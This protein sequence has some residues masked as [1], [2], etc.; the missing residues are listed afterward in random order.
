MR[1]RRNNLITRWGGFTLIELLV[2]VAILSLLVSILLPSLTKAKELAR[3]A[4]CYANLRSLNIAFLLYLEDNHRKFFPYQKNCTDGTL[5][6]WGFEPDGSGP[7]GQRQIDPRRARLAPYFP[8]T[9]KVQACPSIPMDAGYWKG[10]FDL[11]GYGYG[12]NYYLLSE[13]NP[14]VSF[15]DIARPSDTIVWGD[16]VQI[17]TWQAPASPSNPML[18]EWYWLVNQRGTGA[19]F[20]FRHLKTCTAVMADGSIW[21]L[22]PYWLDERCDGLVGRPEE[23][24][25][26]PA[27]GETA[28][29]SFLLRLGAK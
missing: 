14:G 1:K 28:T 12:I 24:P 13:H 15:E 9:G 22:K 25:A 21:A 26:Y 23:P 5:W 6:Y 7:E 8:S 17:N 4:V 16:C 2:V 19:V 10:K 27:G 20:H 18:E 3:Q 29:A 11:A